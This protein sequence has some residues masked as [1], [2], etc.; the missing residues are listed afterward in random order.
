[1]YAYL[2]YSVH[3]PQFLKLYVALPIHEIKER[4]NFWQFGIVLLSFAFCSSFACVHGVRVIVFYCIVAYLW[5][6][7]RYSPCHAN[8]RRSQCERPPRKIRLSLISEGMQKPCNSKQWGSRDRKLAPERERER[9]TDR[10]RER[11]RVTDRQRQT[12][13][14]GNRQTRFGHDS[15]RPRN[16][17]F[18][19][20][21]SVKRSQRSRWGSRFIMT[22]VNNHNNCLQLTNI[23]QH[24]MQFIIRILIRILIRF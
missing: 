23:R 6:Y 12:T 2:S 22:K 19:S 1:M 15:S 21:R 5:I 7:L 10:D 3:V 18:K 8:R 16:K 9:E 20:S 4:H 17:E 14:E 24:C 11:D 13:G